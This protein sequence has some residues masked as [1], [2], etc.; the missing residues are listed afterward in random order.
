MAMAL[1]MPAFRSAPW[2]LPSISP[3][4]S[5]SPRRKFVSFYR[6]IV[7]EIHLKPMPFDMIRAASKQSSNL[8]A[9]RHLTAVPASLSSASPEEDSASFPSEEQGPKVDLNH[10]RRRLQ[11]SFTCNA[12]GVRSDRLINPHAYA[13]GTV[14]VQCAGCDVYHQLVDNL[15]LIEEYDFRQETNSKAD[16]SDLNVLE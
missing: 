16:D 3:S 8:Q 12:C 13:R 4:S 7:K 10:P 11:V 14:F 1:C 6:P 15:N 9:R 5:S 2:P